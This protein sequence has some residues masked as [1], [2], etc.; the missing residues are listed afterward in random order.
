MSAPYDRLLE[1]A[2]VLEKRTGRKRHNVVVVLGSGLGEYAKRLEDPIAIPYTDLPGFPL[3]IQQLTGSA[4]PTRTL[5][6]PLKGRR[7]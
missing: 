5:R 6:A 1:T 7:P 2:A 3:P 4:I